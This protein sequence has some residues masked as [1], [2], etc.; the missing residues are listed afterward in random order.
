MRLD[1]TATPPCSP[2]SGCMWL[3][4]WQPSRRAATW[5]EVHTVATRHLH[6][7]L[8]NSEGRAT[9]ARYVLSAMRVLLPLAAQ[10]TTEL[11]AI[12]SLSCCCHW[13]AV[14]KSLAAT[15]L[16]FI[17]FARYTYVKYFEVVDA[18]IEGQPPSHVGTQYKH[19][20]RSTG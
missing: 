3:C 12:S 20:S 16:K 10:V 5:D 17:Y 9:Y 4:N 7:Y 2:S 8:R 6:M 18:I 11:T 19:L 1:A 14:E 15:T 13:K